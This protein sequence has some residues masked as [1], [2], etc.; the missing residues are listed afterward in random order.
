[1]KARKKE[2]Y[3]PATGTSQKSN[4]PSTLA[5]VE[6]HLSFLSNLSLKAQCLILFFIGFLLYANTINNNYALDDLMVY[7]QNDHTKKGFAGIKALLTKDSFDGF[8]KGQKN[9]LPGGR[10]RPLSII[11]FAIEYQ[12]WKES[13]GITHAINALLYGITIVII[14]LLLRNFMFRR[15]ADIAFLTA[16]LFAFHPIHTEAI[17]NI[18]SRD[19]ILS[20]LF[21][22]LSQYWLFMHLYKN[23]P[24]QPYLTFSSSNKDAPPLN[25]GKSENALYFILSLFA[26]FLA[27]LSKENGLTYLAII[28]LTLYFFTNLPRQSILKITGSYLGVVI[29]YLLIR[30]A[31]SG[32]NF[33]NSTIVLNNA[34]IYATKAEQIATNI[35]TLQKYINLLFFPHPLTWDYTYKQIN[36]Y[37][38]SSPAFIIAFLIHLA[39]L[40][41]A[42][43]GL[44]SKNAL[45]YATLYYFFSIFIVSGLVI[46]IGGAFL[47]ERFLYQGSLGF[48]LILA[49]GIYGLYQKFNSPTAK[50]A[51]I[52][53]ILLPAFLL[54]GFRT[55]QRNTTWKD[56][57]SLF[58]NDADISDKSAMAN[59]AGGSAWLQLGIEILKRGNK[60]SLSIAK[61]YIA[62]GQAYLRKAISIFPEYPEPYMDIGLSYFA[63]ENVDSAEYFW[64]EA[65]KYS[66][67]NPFIKQHNEMLSRALTDKAAK[68]FARNEVQNAIDILNRSVTYN[69]L[70]HNAWTQLAVYYLKQNNLDQA[71]AAAQEAVKI[72]P[73]DPNY[74]YNLGA[75]YFKKGEKAKA[76]EAFETCL[77]VK[78]DHPAAPEMLAKAKL[79]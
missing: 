70:N 28:P 58:I 2:L 57:N 51:F 50:N 36:Y 62:K 74:L 14:F 61:S 21:L 63:L 15:T 76:I 9:T 34:F 67:H 30:T 72:L 6:F 56:S 66:P 13:P 10:Y 19:E 11:T 55:L 60:D 5:P 54:M 17:A 31:A 7:T 41:Y 68:A 32:A 71:L 64:L 39:L 52:A 59:K 73:T 4:Q 33:Q 38:F 77:K 47:A 12:F 79:L 8:T 22:L 49:I 75:I 20:L 78:P 23:K 29:L 69:P 65:R 44:K 26:L 42:I 35:V 25:T 3:N 24:Y 27:L 45:S 1:M 46:S 18:K 48:C 53:I 16:T 43:M 40:A 37:H